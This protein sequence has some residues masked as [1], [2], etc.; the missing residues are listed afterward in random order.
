MFFST[1]EAAQKECDERN[2]RIRRYP[3]R[4]FHGQLWVPVHHN[5]KW[6][7]IECRPVGE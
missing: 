6:W 2:A 7:R 4:M 5:G 1:E 3:E